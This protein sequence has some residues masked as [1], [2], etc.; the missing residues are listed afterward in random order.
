MIVTGSMQAIDIVEFA[1]ENSPSW[2][3]MFQ[4]LSSGK[5]ASVGCCLMLTFPVWRAY[6]YMLVMGQSSKNVLV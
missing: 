5:P 6:H 3:A 1:A 4:R 2:P